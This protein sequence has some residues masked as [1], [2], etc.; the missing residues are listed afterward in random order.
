MGDD[1]EL[2]DDLLELAG[3]SDEIPT[4]YEI[5]WVDDGVIEVRGV[6]AF[7]QHITRF[8]ASYGLVLWREQVE[9]YVEEFSI[10]ECGIP[11]TYT[12]W[13]DEY[14]ESDAFVDGPAF[15]NPPTEIEIVGGGVMSRMVRRAVREL[16]GPYGYDSDEFVVYNCLPRPV[17]VLRDGVGAILIAP[18]WLTED[19][20][21]SS[22]LL[23][24]YYDEFEDRYEV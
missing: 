19:G 20:W 4:G 2:P 7:P 9:E 12:E 21:D 1:E 5:D 6:E 10:D 14:D 15:D 3:W 24:R 22:E 18:Y 17:V 23:T 8:P 11:E 16:A 13:D